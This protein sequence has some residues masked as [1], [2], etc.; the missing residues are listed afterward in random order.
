[1]KFRV[2]RSV[3]ET[4]PVGV[5]V[6]GLL[7]RLVVVPVAVRLRRWPWKKTDPAWADCT[8]TRL[9]TKVSFGAKCD[10]VTATVSKKLEMQP[11]VDR[12]PVVPAERALR[13][14][15]VPL[16]VARARKSCAGFTSVVPAATP[17][18]STASA[19]LSS[20]KPWA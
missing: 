20:S 15:A 3:K 4:Q 12:V 8:A 17:S 2:S 10:R 9:G 14:A 1:M 7:V 19:E 11:V 6:P 18:C 5:R 13:V 16:A